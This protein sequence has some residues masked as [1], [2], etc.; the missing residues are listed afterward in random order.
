MC[1]YKSDLKR[2]DCGQ[3][4]C[5]DAGNSI[6]ET[7]ISN[8]LAHTH[9]SPPTLFPDSRSAAVLCDYSTVY[10]FQFFQ[11]Q[12]DNNALLDPVFVEVGRMK[13]VKV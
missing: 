13:I 3:N 1:Y 12:E 9:F 10:R 2:L 4:C 11:V 6:S 5:Q 7:Q 8:I